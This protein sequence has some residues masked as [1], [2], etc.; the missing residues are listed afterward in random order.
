ML[1]RGQAIDQFLDKPFEDQPCLFVGCFVL[2]KPRPLI[3]KRQ[4]RQEIQ[5]YP[6][7][8]EDMGAPPKG[9]AQNNFLEGTSKEG[10]LQRKS[11]PA[12]ILPVLSAL[13]SP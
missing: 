2:C 11:R 5:P 1:K 7:S 13:V 6:I 4:I 8:K 10:N 12:E 9:I 3:V